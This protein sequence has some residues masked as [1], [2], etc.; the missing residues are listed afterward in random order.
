MPRPLRSIAL[1]VALIGCGDKDADDTGPGGAVG[2]DTGEPDTGDTGGPTAVDAD[3]DGYDE[4]ADCDDADPAVYPGAVE[5]CNGV[6]DDCDD[7]IDEDAVD[8]LALFVD[9]DGDGSGAEP[10]EA[11]AIGDGL[12][13]VDGDCDDADPAVHPGAPEVGCN[14]VDDDCDGTIDVNR[15][16]TDHADL[17]TAVAALADGAEICV[18]PGVYAETLD[19]TGREL[20][21]TGQ[22]GAA[23]T[24]LDLGTTAPMVSIMGEADTE[25]GGD[26]GFTG[27]TLTGG[28]FTAAGT[29]LEGGFAHVEGGTLRLTDIAFTDTTAAMSDLGT[30]SGLLVW[31]QDATLSLDGVTVSGIDASMSGGSDGERLLGG[32]A[33]GLGSAVEVS[34]LTVT[35]VSFTGSAT[36]DACTVRGG[37]LM[38]DEGSTLTASDVHISGVDIDLSCATRAL[39][40]GALIYVYDS[41]S[42]LTNVSATG[43][44]VALAASRTATASALISGTGWLSGASQDWSVIE[45]TDNDLNTE[46]SRPLVYG[47]L[48][49]DGGA[50]SH[51]TY[52][53]NTARATG[54]GEGRSGSMAGMALSAGDIDAAYLDIRHNTGHGDDYSAAMVAV[55]AAGLDRT[56]R[57]FI[58]AGNTLS[59][60]SLLGMALYAGA[61]SATMTVQHGDIVG[62]T[63]TGAVPYGEGVVTAGGEDSAARVAFDHVQIVGNTLV[64]DDDLLALYTWEAPGDVLD[65]SYCNLFGAD[66]ESSWGAMSGADGN[67]SADPLYTDVSGADATTWDLS[68]GAGSPAIDAGDP[69]T[70]DTDGSTADLGAYGG[71]YGAW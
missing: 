43:N 38:V 66:V 67:I 54:T 5:T 26:V 55:Y 16:P 12:A 21:F 29:A 4:A 51:F 46:S 37:V 64:G 9:G 27:F 45:L 31:G 19:L 3:G 7:E 24:T 63:F 50:L 33:F 69:A 57:N 56:L 1:L 10:T 11:C 2:D 15:V 61:E 22:G 48:S 71:S 20:E 58:I 53:N 6:D 36:R 14:G 25:V 30:L 52:W 39:A 40:S 59:G 70:L 44:R 41:G 34:D 18:E 8:M 42:T 13:A 65:V 49:I 17:A 35:D 23:A 32:I 47:G 28:D 68:L 60:Y 62:N